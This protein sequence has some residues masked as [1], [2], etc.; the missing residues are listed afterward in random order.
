MFNANEVLKQWNESNGMKKAMTD[1][2]DNKAKIEFIEDLI[3]EENLN[4]G[5]YPYLKTTGKNGG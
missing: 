4:M 2:F 3:L 1:F 5:N